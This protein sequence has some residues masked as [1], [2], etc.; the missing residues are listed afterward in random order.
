MLKIVGF[1]GFCVVVGQIAGYTWLAKLDEAG[2]SRRV[3]RSNLGRTHIRL[4]R[5]NTWTA[6][7]RSTRPEY[8]LILQSPRGSRVVLI[9]SDA[10]LPAISARLEAQS[11]PLP[12]LHG[13]FAGVLAG[14]APNAREAAAVAS[15]ALGAPS[16][17]SS[18]TADQPNRCLKGFRY[19]FIDAGKGWTVIATCDSARWN[20]TFP[21]LKRIV[22][23]LE[24]D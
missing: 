2:T 17:V 22:T 4:W 9:G 1:A 16:L 3:F 5:P 7:L 14:E 21:V 23:S 10:L 13:A 11:D 8:R 24:I 12:T 19:T 15:K 20:K 18:F 6:S